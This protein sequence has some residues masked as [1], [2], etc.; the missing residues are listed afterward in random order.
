MEAIAIV[1]RIVLPGMYRWK[2]EAENSLFFVGL[3]KA[4]AVSETE[5]VASVFRLLFLLPKEAKERSSSNG[6]GPRFCLS[7]PDA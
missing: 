7:V 2:K 3:L 6:N 1:R 5:K 4:H